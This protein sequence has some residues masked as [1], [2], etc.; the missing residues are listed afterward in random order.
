MSL[1]KIYRGFINGL[2]KW[3]D[4][5]EVFKMHCAERI[6]IRKKKSV[7]EAVKWSND[8]QI[9][10]DSFWIDAYGIKIPN[11]W[12]RLYQATSNSFSVDYIPE[13]LYSTRIEPFY[14]DR[15]YAKVLQDK[16]MLETLCGNCGCIVPKTILVCSNGY[17]FDKDRNP[18]T[19]D[20]AAV[21][22]KEV[23]SYVIKPT[24]GSSSGKGIVFGQNSNEQELSELKGVL[25]KQGK[26]YIVQHVIEQHPDLEIY[27]PS[28]INTIRV[29]TYITENGY[30]HFPIAFRIGR[31]GSRVDNIHAGGLVIG[32]ND[33]GYLLPVAY[34]LG[35]GE[36]DSKY[37]EHPDSKIV[38]EG[39]KLPIIPEIIDAAYKVHGHLPHIG[40]VSWDFTVDKEVR[41]V[42]IEANIIGQSIWFPQIAH[43]KGAF[44]DYTKELLKKIKK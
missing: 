43:G 19:E 25:S 41:P 8:Q 36:K 35:Y 40:I 28:S 14:N 5:I 37:Q 9:A 21:L 12:H 33:E 11:K 10:F 13:M 27:N 17:L 42:L 24:V 4:R 15:K 39:R 20:Q 18:I 32:V 29:I 1:Q 22:L 6:A 26:D 23:C 16:S 38:F 31:S 30:R 3:P 7:Y 34:E 44:E 2:D